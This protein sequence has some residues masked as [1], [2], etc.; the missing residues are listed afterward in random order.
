MWDTVTRVLECPN[1]G[2]PLAPTRFARSVVC[3]FCQSTVQVDP[4][5]VSVA[6]FRQ[7]LAAWNS[8]ETHGYTSFS[9]IGESHWATR[10]FI[11]RG[12][13][14][15]VYLAERARWPTERVLLKILREPEHG[16]LFD[17]EWDVLDKLQQ[18]EAPGAAL[19]TTLVPQPVV[20]GLVDNGP[21][22]GRRAMAF[23]WATGFC[24]TLEGVRRAYPQGINPQISIWMWRRILELLTFLHRSG[25]VHG[26]VLPPHILVQDGDHG[27]RLVGY[28]AAGGSGTPLATVCSRFE[29]FYPARRLSP[30]ADVSM[31]AR[32]IAFILG[33]EGACVDVPASVP[34]PLAALI[35]KVAADGAEDAWKV[36]ESVGKTARARYGPPTFHPLMM[37]S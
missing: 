27:I 1:C 2:A 20:R 11:A 36:R 5:A 3:S 4:R 22:R 26:A 29:L 30:G 37:P 10:H 35:R 33:G 12:E 8:P 14:S 15:D 19:F 18:S 17:R 31:S 28:S 24:E 21:Y 13:I 7:A 6:L 34:E 9:S 23:R 25:V 32:S 16:P